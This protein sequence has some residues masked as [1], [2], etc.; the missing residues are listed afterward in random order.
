[1]T[2]GSVP[3][4]MADRLAGRRD[5]KKKIKKKIITTRLLNFRIIKNHS[6][7]NNVRVSN[8]KRKF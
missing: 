1:M 7:E 2:S 8:K 6:K 5:K 4:L 3:E